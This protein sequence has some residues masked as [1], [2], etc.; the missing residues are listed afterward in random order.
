MDFHACRLAYINFVIERGATVKE[1][2]ALARHSTP[3]LTMNVYGRTRP[4]RLAETVE[5][6][7]GNILL[8][9]E[10]NVPSMYRQAVGAETKSAT[11]E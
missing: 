5:K 7:A 11:S 2:Q 4:E 3:D 8:P 6:M 9:D 1:A 10:K